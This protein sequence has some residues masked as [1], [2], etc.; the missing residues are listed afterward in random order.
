VTVSA[1]APKQGKG[2]HFNHV[3]EGK[4]C[5]QNR[6]NVNVLY[7]LP[8]AESG[9][10][11]PEH[12]AETRLDYAELRLTGLHKVRFKPPQSQL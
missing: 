12:S 2:S 7:N 5:L 6:E 8:T 3:S 10:H 9:A 11:L 4:G 1:V